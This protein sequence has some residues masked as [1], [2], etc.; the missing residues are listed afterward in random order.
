MLRC[1]ILGKNLANGP[2]TERYFDITE[3]AVFT[4]NYNET[5]DSGNIMIQQLPAKIEIEP[6]DAIVIESYGDGLSIT[7]RRM[8]VDTV[9]CSRTSVNPPI[10]GYQISLFSETKLLENVVCPNL[11][12]TR[13]AEGPVRHVSDYLQTYLDVFGPKVD[14]NEILGAHTNKYSLAPSTL[15]RF[16]D[17]VCPEFQWNQPTLREVLNDLMMVDD[18]IP[19]LRNGELHYIDVS[20]FGS[21][22]TDAQKTGVNYVT[23]SQSSEDYV[24][25]IKMHLVNAA[26]NS[27]PN[28]GAVPDDVTRVV[29]E[30][31]FRNNQS[32]LLT[33]E[34]MRLQTSFPIW[35]IFKC[36]AKVKFKGTIYILDPETS[37][38]DSLTL[39]TTGSVDITPYIL[40][41]AEWLTK[42]V[43]YGAWSLSTLYLDTNYRNKCL[44]YTRGAKN[45]ENFNEKVEN[46]FLWIVNSRYV[47]QMILDMLGRQIANDMAPGWAITR[48]DYDL[49][50]ETD[51]RTARF[52]LDYEAIDDCVFSASKSPFRKNRRQIIDNQANSYVDTNRQGFL[53]YLKA[54]RL[55]NLIAQINARYYADESAIPHFS[56]SEP[57]PTFEGKIIYNRQISVYSR[58]IDVNFQATENYVLRD[59]YTGVR[60]K[61]RSWRVVS[62]SE[63]LIRAEL[64]KFYVNQNIQ[65]VSNSERVIPSYA[66]LSSYL[67]RFKYCAIRFDDRFPAPIEYRGITYPVN[68]VQVEFTKHR[69]GKSVVFTIRMEDNYYV[70]NYVSNYH[71]TG[72]TNQN[73]A[74]QKGI[75]Y[76]DS[77]GEMASCVICFYERCNP[78]GFNDEEADSA[79]KPL[80][81][82]GMT[83]G[84]SDGENL[85]SSDMVAKIPV[86]VHKDNKEIFQISIQFE[87][88]EYANDMF[89]GQK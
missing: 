37:D 63:A 68:A 71:G 11:A 15:A 5:L 73:R 88:N 7:T 9:S 84:G 66:D 49:T 72:G 57:A 54:N 50:P 33:T 44:Y 65:S 25:D 21:E 69:V 32:Y 10:Y 67:E 78:D 2:G 55:G 35:K 64:V 19:V 43:Y 52:K 4:E 59:Y 3:G 18:C 16:S 86:T 30:I 13:L 26:N 22:M 81:S 45:V 83:A 36:I 28:G 34:N 46:Q 31:G 6:Y 56:V 24:S 48:I 38:T 77:N 89:L 62:G 79:L 41:Y 76:A 42:D 47:Y 27:I 20:Q 58:H 53:E 61:L 14:S 87:L 8:C 40:E 80:V 39:N 12:I 70:G 85:N 1:K 51:F 23:E 82:A 17:I 74:E 60:S 75:R 29:E